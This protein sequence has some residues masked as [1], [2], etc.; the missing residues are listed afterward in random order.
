MRKTNNQ[1][2]GI[3]VNRQNEQDKKDSVD[4]PLSESKKGKEHD[5]ES[6]ILASIQETLNN[7]TEAFSV[8]VKRYT[9]ILYSLSY[10]I[11]G[12]TDEAEDIVQEIFLKVFA[13]LHK[14]KIEN[15][16]LPW[17]YTIAL[18]HLRSFKKKRSRQQ[19][20]RLVHID[21]ENSAELCDTRQSDP[22]HLLVNKEAETYAWKALKKLKPEYREVFI[23]RDLEGLSVKEVSTIL[24]IPEGTVK[25]HLHRA[26]KKLI[27]ELTSKDF[28]KP[29]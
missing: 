8:I 9:P 7:N 22:A 5:D 1:R 21:K 19:K 23:L 11:L 10:K 13:S 2:K 6:R 18:N 20:I 25:T 12:Y 15:R 26:K 29:G 16:F 14:F 28:L 17:I 27:K 4:I 3:I 24:N